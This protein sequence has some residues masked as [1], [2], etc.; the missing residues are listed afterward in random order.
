[1][2]ERC[3][4]VLMADSFVVTSRGSIR[5]LQVVGAAPSLASCHKDYHRSGATRD[6]R[7]RVGVGPLVAAPGDDL[8][9]ADQCELGAVQVGE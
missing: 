8:V 5:A 2:A 6:H 3:S 9:R 4:F 7:E 1:M